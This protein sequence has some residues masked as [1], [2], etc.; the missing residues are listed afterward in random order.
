MAYKIFTKGNYLH[1]VNSSDG[2][3]YEA[4]AKD[5]LVRKKF[6]DSESY[7]FKGVNGF[8]DALEVPFTDIQDEN[9]DAYADVATWETWYSANTGNFNTGG[10]TPQV[11]VYNARYIPDGVSDPTV[12]IVENTT[13]LT[14]DVSRSSTGYYI[15]TFSET[16]TNEY[17][18]FS[19]VNTDGTGGE[20][21][22]V[23][24]ALSTNAIETTTSISNTLTDDVG[25]SILLY[26]KQ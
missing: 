16:I 25:F 7:W 9:G 24:S 4:L 3:D 26:L 6:E 11:T 12:Q 22:A 17:S 21:I 8:P 23:I 18:L 5:V 13:G 20:T 10:A 19:S 1:I 14:V 2:T 15:T